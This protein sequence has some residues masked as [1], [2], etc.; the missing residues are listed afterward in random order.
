M[1]ISIAWWHSIDVVNLIMT[2]HL[3]P[4]HTTGTKTFTVSVCSVCWET[5]LLSVCRLYFT[6]VMTVN[7]KCPLRVYLRWQGSTEWGEM[8]S[9]LIILPPAAQQIPTLS[10]PHYTKIKFF[11]DFENWLHKSS[12]SKIGSSR[13][14]FWHFVWTSDLTTSNHPPPIHTLQN[15]TLSWRTLWTLQ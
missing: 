2:E 10:P 7:H 8:W 15:W 5:T 3:N 13:G 4:I 11:V 1:I 12:P 6:T 14:E 9:K